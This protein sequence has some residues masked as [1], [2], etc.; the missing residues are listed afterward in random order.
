VDFWSATFDVDAVG[1]ANIDI[2]FEDL[3]MDEQ[4]GGGEYLLS[5]GCA[6]MKSAGVRV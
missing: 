6:S 5:G 2:P 3:E 4:I 1:R